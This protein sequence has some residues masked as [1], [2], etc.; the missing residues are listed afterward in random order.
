DE[1]AKDLKDGSSCLLGCTTSLLLGDS[2]SDWL[3]MSVELSL[4][5]SLLKNGTS[6]RVDPSISTFSSSLLENGTSTRD[7]SSASLFSISLLE[8]GTSTRVG[9]KS[10]RLSSLA[11]VLIPLISM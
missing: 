3:L 7:G 6:T 4:S 9:L 8:K 2:L 5:S 11:E 1:R 10:S